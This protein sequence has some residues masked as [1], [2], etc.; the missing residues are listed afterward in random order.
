MHRSLRSTLLTIA[1]GIFI[2]AAQATATTITA[3]TFPG[4]KSALTGSPT[5]LNFQT[6][7]YTSYNTS[8]GITLAAMGNPSI[9]FTFTGPD[10]SGWALQGTSYNGYVGLAGSTDSGAAIKVTMPSGG[11]NAILLSVASTSGTP[12]TL[13]LS[14]GESFTVSGGLF[15]M[16]ISHTITWLSLSTTAGSQAIIDDFLYGTSSLTQDGNGGGSQNPATTPE[17]A[18]AILVAAG[19]LILIGVRRKF[20]FIGEGLAALARR[21]RAVGRR[22]DSCGSTAV[23]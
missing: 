9:G 21:S 18:T 16:S 17:G 11:E 4:W 15:G 22:A 23:A 10:G 5:D 3:T 20:G 13:T 6:V 19:A 8:L 14:D 7:S 1:A 2:T 12:L